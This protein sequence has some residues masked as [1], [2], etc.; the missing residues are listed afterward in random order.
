MDFIG[1]QCR[2]CASGDAPEQGDNPV[3]R[4]HEDGLLLRHCGRIRTDDL[5]GAP[6]AGQF[7][8]SRDRV[9]VGAIE[10]LFSAPDDVVG[11]KRFGHLQAFIPD[12]DHD[13]FAGAA[14]SRHFGMQTPD[15]S[16]SNNHNRLT[17]FHIHRVL[18]GIHRGTA[19]P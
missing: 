15:W 6:P 5:V 3:F 12:F 9:A 16:G 1:I 7:Q 17:N 4:A 19:A 2:K 18:A 13:D 11:A 10:E 8:H 14:Y